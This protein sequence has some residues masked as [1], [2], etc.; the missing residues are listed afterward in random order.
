MQDVSRRHAVDHL[1]APLARCIGLD[2]MALDRLGRQPLVPEDDGHLDQAGKVAREGP[3]RLGA[4]SLRPIEIKGKADYQGASSGTKTL[5]SFD[6]R[7]QAV[8]NLKLEPKK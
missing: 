8:I 5:T 3:R 6:T 7:P 1:G 2:E 4:R